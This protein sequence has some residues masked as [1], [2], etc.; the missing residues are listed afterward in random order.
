[1]RQ[2]STPSLPFAKL[3]NCGCPVLHFC[4][5]IVIFQSLISSISRA[6]IW[7]LYCNLPNLDNANVIC[8]ILKSS[9][10]YTEIFT[11][12]LFCQILFTVNATHWIVNITSI[13]CWFLTPSMPCAEFQTSLLSCAEFWHRQCHVPN[14]KHHLYLVLNV[15]TVNAMCQILDIASI[16][17]PV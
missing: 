11:S 9:M 10:S 16:L 4:I 17:C 5:V 13:V 12:L 6:N 2:I 7:L 3:I 14:F 15:D 8:W 1:M